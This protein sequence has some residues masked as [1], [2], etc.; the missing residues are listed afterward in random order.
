[1]DYVTSGYVLAGFLILYGAAY[2][3]IGGQLADN[4]KSW[5]SWSNVLRV[6]GG[7]YVLLSLLSVYVATGSSLYVSNHAP[8][9]TV[10]NST[11]VNGSVTHY[12]YTEGPSCGKVPST[13]ERMYITL[14][15]VVFISFALVAVGLL[16]LI[17]RVIY[18]W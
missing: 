16:T 3:W 1:M 6:L 15:W 18:K 14:G 13:S 4:N 17:V 12:T 10:I 9:E 8:C 2:F 7:M 11:T 5:L